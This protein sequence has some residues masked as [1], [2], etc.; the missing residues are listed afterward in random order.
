MRLLLVPALLFVST[1]SVAVAQQ[2]GNAPFCVVTPY[3]TECYYYDAPSC[4]A[5]ARQDS[6]MCVPATP[7]SQAPQR[8]IWD[9]VEAG[10]QTGEA[11]RNN[12]AQSA[13]PPPRTPAPT[14]APSQTQR[15]FCNQVALAA[16]SSLQSVSDGDEWS[17]RFAE[18]ERSHGRC[19]QAGQ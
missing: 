6:G 10:A 4:R 1:P 7:T 11:M 17:R 5:A 19:V 15:D 2:V 14:A 12:R 18:I 13:L 3:R 8:S 16:V 9:S